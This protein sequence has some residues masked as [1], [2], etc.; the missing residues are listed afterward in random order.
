VL[1]LEAGSPERS[2]VLVVGEETKLVQ[3]LEALDTF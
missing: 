3:L 2:N 1:E